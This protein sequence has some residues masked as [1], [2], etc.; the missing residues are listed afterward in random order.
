MQSLVCKHPIKAQVTCSDLI[1]DDGHEPF[2]QQ[3][4]WQSLETEEA[5]ASELAISRLKL[6]PGSSDTL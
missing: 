6:T 1:R 5:R 4:Y 2:K 3:G